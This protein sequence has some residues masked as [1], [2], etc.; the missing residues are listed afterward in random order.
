MKYI[1]QANGMTWIWTMFLRF[2]CCLAEY[3]IG[4]LVRCFQYFIAAQQNISL[5]AWCDVFAIS[6]LPSIIFHWLPGAMFLVFHCCLARH[7]IGCL[8]RRFCDFFAAQGVFH[9]SLGKYFIDCLK[10]CFWLPKVTSVTHQSHIKMV[11]IISSDTMV[12]FMCHTFVTPLSHRVTPF[13]QLKN[14]KSKFSL[15]AA[16]LGF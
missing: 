3:F 8:V 1:L 11:S 7:F 14:F 16:L 10:R 6:L 4:C 5:V 15:R 13:K 12:N 2:L 9:C